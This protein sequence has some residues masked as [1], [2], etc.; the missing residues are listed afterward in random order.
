EE[1]GHEL[2]LVL[3][4]ELERLP[5][6]YRTPL[7]L[8][9]LEGLTN[10]EVAEHVGAPIGTI[11][12]R[13]SRGRELLRVRLTR[14][15][16]ALSAGLLGTVL[17]QQAPAAPLPVGLV[18]STVQAAVLFAAGAAA[19]GALSPNVVALTEGVLKMMWFNKL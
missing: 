17:A 5:E 8:S 3:D 4:E 19:G 14:R 2:R 12:T 11:F 13:L 1:A 10:R 6:K 18:Q 7:V 9:Y 16:L 15:G